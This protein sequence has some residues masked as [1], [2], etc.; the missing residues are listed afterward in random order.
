MDRWQYL[1]VM[2]ACLL[3]TAPLEYAGAGV[4]RRPRRLLGALLPVA[5][6]FL[7]WDA[8]AAAARVWW[9]NP[10]YLTGAHLLGLP[11]EEWVFFL[12]IPVCGVLTFEAVGRLLPITP[13]TGRSPFARAWPPRGQ[14]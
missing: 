3:L 8:I 5:A 13:H 4:Y 9:Y 1:A 7:C 2:V 10:A 12:V 6:V 14:R 11:I